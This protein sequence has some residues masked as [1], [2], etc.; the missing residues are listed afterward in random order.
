M[1]HTLE[2]RNPAGGPGSGTT[3]AA[4]APLGHGSPLDAVLQRLDAVQKSGAGYRSQCPACAGRSRKLSIS[5][6]NNGS[7]LLHCF[8]GCPALSIVHA[9]GLSL[10]DLFP[11][12]LAPQTAQERRSAWLFARHGHWGAALEVLATEALI[13]LF[14]GQQLATWRY[15]SEEDDR[16]LELACNRIEQAKAILRE[17]PR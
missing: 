6:A 9:V 5:E 7:V 1:T 8:A 10:A 16:R 15:L 17:T 3:H 11:A 2:K 13:V 14:A 4:S 12:R